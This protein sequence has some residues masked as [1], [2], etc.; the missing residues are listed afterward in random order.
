MLSRSSRAVLIAAIACLAS[1]L[2]AASAEAILS[3]THI[4]TPSVT[5]YPLS[6][7]TAEG[8]PITISGT[9]L[10]AKELDIRCYYSAAE[11]GYYTIAQEVPVSEE[12]G[13]FTTTAARSKFASHPVLCRLRAVPT[14]AKL[15]LPP[16]EEEEFNGPLVAPA[17]FELGTP[18]YSAT[19]NSPT[20]YLYAQQ[21]EGCGLESHLVVPATLIASNYLFYCNAG[22]VDAP[23]KGEPGTLIDGAAAYGPAAGAKIEETLKTKAPLPGAPQITIVNKSFDETNG[24]MSVT[25]RDPFVRCSPEANIDPPTETSCTSFAATGVTLERTWTFGS[26]DHVATMLDVWRSTDG[27]AHEVATNY[28]NEFEQNKKVGEQGAFLFAG[29]S[30]F[31]GTTAEETIGLPSGPGTI[32][33]KHNN[34]TTEAG[35][36]IEPQGAIAYDRP[37]S[38]PLKVTEPTNGGSNNTIYFAPYALKVPANGSSV[39][40]MTFIQGFGLPE[41]RSAAET[42]IAGF[43]PSVSIT[44]PANGASVGTASPSVTVSGTAAD[45]GAIA[46]VSVNGVAATLGAGG[47]WSAS[48]PL[49]A[50]SNALTATATDQAGLARTASVTVT[51]K[52][53]PTPP[54]PAATATLAG[55]ITTNRGNVIFHVICKGAEGTFC[56]LNDALT[57]LERL[58]KGRLIGLLARIT[59]RKL[60]VATAHQLIF[61]GREVKVTLK[62]NALGKELLKRFHKLPV[63]L[64]VTLNLKST[65]ST[66]ISKNVLVSAPA[67]RKRTRKR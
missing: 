63:H 2:G 4:T 37:P 13:T 59:T 14:G 5:T 50:G 19:S 65:A 28:Y 11:T 55:P 1:A 64:T 6:D 67:T 33:Y 40:R 39:L 21:A 20:G 66:A 30:A 38:G 16:T 18:Y 36:S 43:A 57:T 8:A 35:D 23:G 27:K 61:G 9:V 15:S 34:T 56:S 60:T 31:A 62:L 45:S 7:N 24:N 25:E 41:I 17:S 53:P 51:Y 44:A 49:K 3:V 52:A 47:S 46:S 22:I 54:P 58:K 26:A 42:A 12:T 29:T 48:V 32:F 10:G